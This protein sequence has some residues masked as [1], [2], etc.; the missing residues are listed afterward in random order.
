M[1]IQNV[2][3]PEK[4]EVDSK[5]K[6]NPGLRVTRLLKHSHVVIDLVGG[7]LGALLEAF[8]FLQATPQRLDLTIPADLT[9]ESV[10]I[11][12]EVWLIQTACPPTVGGPLRKIGLLALLAVFRP[13]MIINL[14]R[15]TKMG[16][17]SHRLTSRT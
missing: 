7:R 13:K 11:G 16:T 1:P 3:K 5:Q 12:T 10:P 2:K 9:L 4:I 15:S 8:Q 17:V 6:E 14:G